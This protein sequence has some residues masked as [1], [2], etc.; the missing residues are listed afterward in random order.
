M[1]LA[2]G[3]V[4]WEGREEEFAPLRV[5][6][7][8]PWLPI[9]LA[10]ALW[11][12]GML[13]LTNGH[14]NATTMTSLP[15]HELEGLIALLVTLPAVIGFRAGGWVRRA[16]SH[17]ALLWAGAIS[18][19]TYL[20]HYPLIAWVGGYRA[21]LPNAPGLLSLPTHLPGP[22]TAIVAVFGLALSMG[23]GALSYPLV[24]LPFLRLKRPVPA[25]Q[26]AGVPATDTA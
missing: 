5:I 1:A 19:G 12:V 22:S 8:A 6:V 3:S 26:P 20:W 14:P 18:Y 11:F 7:R 21:A 13:Q 10:F 17:P 24:E 16:L 4:M 23:A 2:V 9:L 15:Q 25:R